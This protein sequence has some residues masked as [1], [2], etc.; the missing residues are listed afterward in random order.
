MLQVIRKQSIS[1]LLTEFIFVMKLYIYI[2]DN[3]WQNAIN[4]VYNGETGH[5]TKCI[6]K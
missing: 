3:L 5:Y 1:G 6:C 2:K 4:M